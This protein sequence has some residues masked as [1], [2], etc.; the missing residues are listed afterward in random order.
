MHRS[1]WRFSGDPAD[2]AGRYDA[3]LAEGPTEDIRFHA[4]FQ[5]SRWR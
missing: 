3:L 1:T 2:L 4:C 5:A